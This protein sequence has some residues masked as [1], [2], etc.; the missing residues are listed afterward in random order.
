[1]ID[2]K[3]NEKCSKCNHWQSKSIKNVSSHDVSTFISLLPNAK[4][5]CIVGGEPLLYKNDILHII[6]RLPPPR[7]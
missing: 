2:K 6:E 1:M 3:C 7:K 5:L 4:E